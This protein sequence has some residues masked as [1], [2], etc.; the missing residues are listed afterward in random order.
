[1]N[2]SAAD[3]GGAVLVVSQFTL[4]GER[5]G[6]G[7]RAGPPSC[8]PARRAAGRCRGAELRALGAEVATGRFRS[9]RVALV[10]DGPV[11]VLVEVSPVGVVDGECRP[12]PWR[13]RRL[14]VGVTA[15]RR[16][17]IR[18]PPAPAASSGLDGR[19]SRQARHR[20][21]PAGARPRV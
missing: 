18:A 2:R 1:M 13:E 6:A 7:A 9:D 5:P 19:P 10:N 8:R 4:Y 21:A 12:R 14:V 20:Q 15:A 17:P 3:A 11:T 16:G